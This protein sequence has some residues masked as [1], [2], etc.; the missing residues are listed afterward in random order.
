M[1]LGPRHSLSKD[2]FSIRPDTPMPEHQW[3]DTAAFRGLS[4]ARSRKPEFLGFAPCGNEP[5][6]CSR[7]S[8]LSHE[9]RVTPW[10]KD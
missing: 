2:V 7:L 8:P 9:H 10:Q 1:D 6:L 4:N 5:Q 3:D